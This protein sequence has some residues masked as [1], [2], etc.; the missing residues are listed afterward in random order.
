MPHLTFRILD[1]DWLRK[2]TPK[3]ETETHQAE[4]EKYDAIS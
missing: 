3:K 4:K 1:H 2:H